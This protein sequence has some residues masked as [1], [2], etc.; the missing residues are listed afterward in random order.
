MGNEKANDLASGTTNLDIVK[1]LLVYREYR[2]WLER[3][4]LSSLRQK[5]WTVNKTHFIVVGGRHQQMFWEVLLARLCA[6]HTKPTHSFLL[7][8]EAPFTLHFLSEAIEY[9]TLY[10][11]S[12]P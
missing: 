4:T 10:I 7:A 6:E 5:A 12:A 9:A 2:N 8:G 1:A 11:I 3:K